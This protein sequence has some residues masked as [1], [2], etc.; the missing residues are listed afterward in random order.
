MINEKATGRKP[1]EISSGLPLYSIMMLGFDGYNRWNLP[2][3]LRFASELKDGIQD[4][5]RFGDPTPLL[6]TIMRNQMIAGVMT[7]RVLRGLI[8]TIEGEEVTVSGGTLFEV[9]PEEW[10]K[11]I[12]LGVYST[13]GG[14]DYIKRM[15]GYDLKTDEVVDKLLKMEEKIG[16]LDK[17]GKPY[18]LLDYAR[19]MT[20]LMESSE[21]GL[22]FAS[23]DLGFPELAM[24]YA[25]SQLAWE[26]YNNL[27]TAPTRVRTEWRRDNPE[28]DA[29]MFLWGRF[30]KPYTG[31]QTKEQRE[32]RLETITSFFPRFGLDPEKSHPRWARNWRVWFE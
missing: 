1:W 9:K 22:I 8:A 27:P 14:K 13:E 3:P 32:L 11:A 23:V 28:I 10:W 6:R 31:D 19:E 12:F 18:L 20:S 5:L 25:V 24:H 2:A 30:E 16:T 15:K 26:E 29:V 7:E 21:I 4:W 17:E